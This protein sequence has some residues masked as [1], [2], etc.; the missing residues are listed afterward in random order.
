MAIK[1]EVV[2][3]DDLGEALGIDPVA[4]KV[5]VLAD[6]TTIRV[7]SDNKLEAVNS[8]GAGLDCDAID[9]LPEAAWKKGT[10]VL[11]KQ[12]GQCVRLTALAS[13]F[14]EV[15][16]GITANKVTAFTDDSF[17]VV[18]TVTNTGEGK[19]DLTNLV[20][21]KPNGGGYTIQDIREAKQDV[22]SFDKTGELS[23]DI[24][25]LA[26][27][28]T[29]TVRFKVVPSEAGTFQFT[30]AVNPN[31]SL[32]LDGKNNTA[33]L[34]LSAQTKKD[35]TYV[36][37]V[38][39]PLITA[40]ELDHNTVLVQSVPV[41]FSG[42]VLIPPRGRAQLNIMAE[43]RSLKGLRIKLDGASTVVG[44]EETSNAYAEGFILLND[45]VS[46]ARITVG[47][48][49]D[50]SID[51]AHN[52][53]KNGKGAYTFTGGVLEITGDVEAFTFSCRPV[54]TNCRW[55]TYSLVSSITPRKRAITVT[56]QDGCTVTKKDTYREER[57]STEQRKLLII[58]TTVSYDK[59][60][61]IGGPYS[62][63]SPTGVDEKLVITVRAGTAATV[64]FTSTDN[65]ADAASSQ[66]K[67]AISAGRVTVAA[68]AK[69]TD[70]VN[71]KYIQ[72]IVED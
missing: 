63:I 35:D 53:V 64:E 11:A 20:I 69:A 22:D 54:G 2:T 57:K 66:G 19:N 59:D 15:G 24:K 10:V 52:A 28:G 37:S 25:G 49:S 43:R 29:F 18:V 31:T 12:D 30:A 47:D 62:R 44:Y 39:C 51:P 72:V 34:I 26:S 56:R 1:K 70:S 13:I 21:N 60:R 50:Y 58:P 36:P 61:L 7:N 3:G 41:D 16:V 8:G 9:Q 5:N 6:G 27:G 4:K 32:D 45:T 55:Q 48:H 17:D 42:T 65:Y 33:T 23:Y 40:T 67:T 68:D 71:T 46:A 38:D 14:Q